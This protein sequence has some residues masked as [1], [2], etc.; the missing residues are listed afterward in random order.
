MDLKKLKGSQMATYQNAI[1]K[2]MT[3]NKLNSFGVA[4]IAVEQ[5]P[6]IDKSLLTGVEINAKNFG[7]NT[8]AEL[9]EFATEL[10]KKLQERF[11]MFFKRCVR[12]NNV[13]SYI[14]DMVYNVKNYSYAML[15]KSDEKYNQFCEE[16]MYD[17]E[18]KNLELFIQEL[19]EYGKSLK[20][21]ID[22]SYQASYS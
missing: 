2:F 14:R 7:E 9:K 5:F 12:D 22:E 20:N 11:E 18:A 8:C 13:K 19:G 3:S 21:L 16:A 6:E 4:C 17:L 1:K 10:E 15:L